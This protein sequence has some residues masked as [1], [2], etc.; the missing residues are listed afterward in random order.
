[1]S[2][3][4]GIRLLV[5]NVFEK[6]TYLPL[7][8]ENFFIAANITLHRRQIALSLN[9]HPSSAPYLSGDTFVFLAQHTLNDGK[10]NIDPNAVKTGDVIFINSHLIHYFFR[11]IHPAIK[12]RYILITHNGDTHIDVPFLSYLDQKI[13][14]W[15]A[16]NVVV[17][18]PQIT[19]IPIGLE[20]LFYYNHGVPLLFDKLKKNPKKKKTQMLME[21][22]LHTNPIVRKPIYQLLKNHPLVNRLQDR[23]AAPRYLEQLAEHQFVLSPPGNGLDCH[24]AWE[25]MYLGTVPIVES[26][27]TTEFFKKL[28]LPLLVVK[29]WEEVSSFDEKKLSE[30]YQQI[31]QKADTSALYYSYW[32]RKILENKKSDSQK[33]ERKK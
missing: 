14:H 7:S 5:S 4:G 24:R 2:I 16:Q 1:M 27:V 29:K 33:K 26:S 17:S 21:F 9:K 18:H 12:K 22:S 32:Q 28:G 25:A 13:I 15:F 6:Y 31:Q 11:C 23:L 10:L 20:N 3:I 8:R 30:L 19:P